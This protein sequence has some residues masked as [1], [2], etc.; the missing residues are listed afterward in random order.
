MSTKSTKTPTSNVI[1]NADK[2]AARLRALKASATDEESIWWASA[3]AFDWDVVRPGNEGTK[4]LS[5]HYT[6]E[7]GVRAR[8]VIRVRGESHVGQIMPL[9]DAGLAEL[10]SNSKNTKRQ[11][12]KRTKK[13]AIQF[14]K[15][16]KEVETEEDGITLKRDQDGNPIT[17]GDGSRS[18]Y[19]AVAELVNEAFSYEA[20]VRVDRGGE[21]TAYVVDSKKKNKALTAKAVLDA[22]NTEHPGPG[23]RMVL[24]P[25]NVTKIRQAFS[26]NQAD[27][28]LLTKGAMITSNVTIT[29][30]VQEYISPKAKQNAGR[31]LPNP[32][33][34]IAMNFNKTTGLPE[35]G[36]SFYD[37]KKPYTADGKTKY[38]QGKVKENDKEYPVNADNVHKFVLS[39]SLID[40]IINMDSVCYSNMGIS[41]PVKAGPLIVEQRES[42]SFGIDDVLGDDDDYGVV[43]NNVATN[44]IV[45]SAKPESLN[46]S[47]L[48]DLL[49]DLSDKGVETK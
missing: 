26:M 21:F 23:L 16:T 11:L 45:A 32:M 4:W 46:A 37:K 18:C 15:W 30:L 38:E 39:R 27:V 42:R 8:L 13:A 31:P 44:E 17:P 3:L 29:S 40:G 48:D 20:R 34:R 47:E 25:D 49:G 19:Y 6:D 22:F 14:Q 7:N 12:E 9:T 2:V 10:T 24:T 28:D 5:I 35:E 1:F 36:L 33:T 43:T 41:I